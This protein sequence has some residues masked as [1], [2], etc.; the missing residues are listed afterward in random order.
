[1]GLVNLLE[2]DTFLNLMSEGEVESLDSTYYLHDRI[3]ILT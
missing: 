1:M 2:F 3:D